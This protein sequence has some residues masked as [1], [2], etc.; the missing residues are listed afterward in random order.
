MMWSS[1]FAVGGVAMVGCL[2]LCWLRYWSWV[3]RMREVAV[4]LSQPGIRPFAELQPL[5]IRQEEYLEYEEA[6][7][8]RYHW[9]LLMG[10]VFFGLAAFCAVLHWTEEW[11]FLLHLPLSVLGCFAALLGCGYLGYGIVRESILPLESGTVE[12]D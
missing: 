2:Y 6:W 12:D 8:T 9:C 10:S 4:E 3:W 5:Y 1:A 7:Y 11:P